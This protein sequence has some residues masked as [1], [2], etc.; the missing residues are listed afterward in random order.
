MF[1]CMHVFMYLCMYV[2]IYVGM[3]VCMYVSMS[4]CMYVCMYVCI[5]LSI[6]LSIPVIGII[7][8]EGGVGGHARLWAGQGGSGGGSVH[9]AAP[10]PCH[11]PWVAVVQRH[12]LNWAERKEELWTC[13]I[14]YFSEKEQK[15]TLTYLLLLHYYLSEDILSDAKAHTYIRP[16]PSFPHILALIQCP[17]HLQHLEVCWTCFCS[18]YIMCWKLC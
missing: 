9:A 14:D 12:L 5:Y 8:Q 3:Y 18:V 10:L 1:V 15:R 11:A 2:C 17:S 16:L 4:V 13:F 7:L 6:Y